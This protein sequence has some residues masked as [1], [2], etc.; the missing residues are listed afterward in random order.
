MS[1][2]ADADRQA[3]RRFFSP[4]GRLLDLPD[5]HPRR[6]FL[7]AHV[8]R[9]FEPGRDYDWREADALLREIHHDHAALRRALVD[10][11]F[12]VRADD[13]YRRIAP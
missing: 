2:D 8:A 10:E 12:L 4:G 6:R 11:G 1:P 7:L 9:R 5:R 13:V 3:L